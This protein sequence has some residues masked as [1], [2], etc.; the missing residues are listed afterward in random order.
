MVAR[1]FPKH[2]RG[3]KGKGKKKKEPARPGRTIG[4][5]KNRNQKYD[6]NTRRQWL[7]EWKV[8][9]STAAIVAERHGIPSS[10]LHRWNKQYRE[11]KLGKKDLHLEVPIPGGV[12]QEDQ[13]VT[14]EKARKEEAARQAPL[15]VRR[16][17]ISLYNFCKS[18]LGYD[19]YPHAHGKFCEFVQEGVEHWAKNREDGRVIQTRRKGELPRGS[20]KSTIVARGVP[21]WLWAEFDPNA[22]INLGSAARALSRTSLA[23]LKAHILHNP[24]FR[25]KYGDWKP[26]SHFDDLSWTRYEI[27]IRPRT[28]FNRAGNSLTTSGVDQVQTGF[29]YD[30]GI[31][32]DIHDPTNVR[33]PEGLEKVWEYYRHMLSLLE[34]DGLLFVIGTAWTENDAYERMDKRIEEQ[35]EEVAAG[36]NVDQTWRGFKCPAQDPDGKLLFPER[37]SASFL[38]DVKKEQ[39]DRIYWTQYMLKRISFE[40]KPFKKEW[41]PRYT[42]VKD[43]PGTLNLYITI[44]PAAGKQKR[45]S[46]WTAV[47]CGGWDS[48]GALWVLDGEFDKIPLSTGVERVLDI[49]DRWDPLYPVRCIAVESVGFQ[50]SWKHELYRA[51]RA[52]KKYYSIQ[53]LKPLNRTKSERI[54]RAEP[55]ARLGMIHLPTRLMR[56]SSYHKNVVNLADTLLSHFTKWPEPSIPKD[57][58]D[59]LA[60]QWDVKSDP[61]R[62]TKL[63]NKLRRTLAPHDR[64]TIRLQSGPPISSGGSRGWMNA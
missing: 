50:E 29:H 54:L 58:L 53:D 31:L 39:G 14:L 13:A 10:Y 3:Q 19:L 41:F 11:G 52:R 48:D 24:Q 55:I 49:A 30:V 20:Y 12:Q 59:S 43:V 2:V 22:R 51:M 60:Y 42:T 45:E 36:V 8:C 57:F 5:P 28:D 6:L 23:V 27:D 32:D 47:T 40:D 62:R 46:D 44:D 16:T 33:T 61:N 34:Q 26:A 15:K 64:E 1:K 7:W 56:Y 4:D 37:L 17:G 35:A 21:L 63:M 9:Q 25:S 18:I 38:A